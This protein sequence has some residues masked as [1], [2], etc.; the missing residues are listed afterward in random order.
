MRI[1]TRVII[2]IRTGEILRSESYDYHGPISEAISFGGNKSKSKQQSNQQ[3]TSESGTRFNEDFLTR[4]LGFLGTKGAAGK[5]TTAGSFDPEGYLLQNPD[6]A[7]SGMDPA[8]HY[9]QYGQAEGR[10]PGGTAQEYEIPGYDP[11]FIRSAFTSGAYTPGAY[12][13]AGYTPVEGGD[14]NRLEEALYGGQKARLTQAYE[15]NVG[16]QREEL[17]QMGALNSPAQF[18]E[19]SARSSMDRSF[20]ENLQQA[21]RD[22]ATTTIGLKAQEAARKT[23]FDVGQAG[24]RTA[25]DVGEA[26][27]R[28]GF[29]VG[30]A[31][32]RTGFGTA[33][34][35]R[36]TGFNE[37]TAQTLLD[38]WLK[39]LAMAIESGRFGT[40]Q[41]TGASS[42]SS[43]AIGGNFGFLSG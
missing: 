34:S 13:G 8:E 20:L 6:V 12:T 38:V 29:D 32:R 15:A 14:F 26:A 19:G 9:K 7:A 41:S 16:R 25:F 17:S 40:G 36:E 37:R 39:K 24:A 22:A 3:S 30:E 1:S 5:Q 33:E 43:S 11:S 18:L 2:D 42:G 27:R 4:A 35:E 31:G 23:G 21:A 10:A 28:T